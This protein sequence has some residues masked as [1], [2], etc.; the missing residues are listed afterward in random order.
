MLSEVANAFEDYFALILAANQLA[1][2]RADEDAMKLILLRRDLSQK[3][4]DVQRI[5]DKFVQ[6]HAIDEAEVSS[7]REHRTMFSAERGAVS[8]H[9]AK[10]N[11]PAMRAARDS[12]ETDVR[13]LFKMHEDN[14][15]WRMRILV[16]ALDA[17][18]ANG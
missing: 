16:P 3:T 11:A 8:R 10:W 6:A 2:E 17:A 1:L 5:V 9:Q 12:Y 7:L 14:H 4:I 18:V 13:A 15:R